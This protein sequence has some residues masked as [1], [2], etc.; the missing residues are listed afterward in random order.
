[1]CSLKVGLICDES[2]APPLYGSFKKSGTCDY[3]TT[4]TGKSACPIFSIGS[5]QKFLKKFSYYW[6]AFFIVTGMC[7]GLFGRK[8]WVAAVFLISSISIICAFL[9]FF[10]INFLKSSTPAWVG[11]TVLVCSILIGIVGGFLMTKLQRLGATIVAAGNGFVI[12]LI[13]SETIL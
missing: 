12:G 11:W 4:Y 1:M 2:G 6:G 3:T 9:I 8:I 7:L 10:Y 5:I 13:L